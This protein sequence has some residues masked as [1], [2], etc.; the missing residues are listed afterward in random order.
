MTGF[1]QGSKDDLI[2]LQHKP[3]YQKEAKTSK[4]QTTIGIQSFVL[5]D[6][7][8]AEVSQRHLILSLD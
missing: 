8:F 7:H 4:A 6:K 2:G 5:K 1:S 3:Y